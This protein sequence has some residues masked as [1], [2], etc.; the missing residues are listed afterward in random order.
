MDDT[1]LGTI[2]PGLDR[3]AWRG[4]VLIER[5]VWLHAATNH[6]ADERSGVQGRRGAAWPPC[7]SP[8]GS[9]GHGPADAA[10]VAQASVALRRTGLPEAH[11]DRAT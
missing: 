6:G 7:R 3:F 4:G 10:G 9:V 8:S 5:G 1:T 11:V 2:M